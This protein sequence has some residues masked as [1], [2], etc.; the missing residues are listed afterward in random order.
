MTDLRITTSD[1]GDAILEEAAVQGL[2]ASL[3]GPLLQPGDAEY[4]ET[5]KV[6]NGMVDRRP[7][8]IARCSGVADVIAAVRYCGGALCPQLQN[9]NL[10]ARRRPQRPGQCRVPRGPDDRSG[11][12]AQCPG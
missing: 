1:G 2:K 4:D 5:R 6:W 9:S 8:L 12:H 10:G 11:R 3:H 7:A